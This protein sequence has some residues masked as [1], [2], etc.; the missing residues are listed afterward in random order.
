[1]T[2]RFVAYYRVS[3]RKQGIHGLG[4]DA[5]REAVRSFLNGCSWELIGEFA[6]V[7]SGKRNKREE[8]QKALAL[9]RQRK[10]TLVIAKLD[11]LSRN[12]AF[13]L[14]LQEAGVEFKAVDMPEADRFMVGIMA[15][16]AQKE[17]EMISERTRQ[18]LRA[19][20]RRGTQLGNPNPHDALKAAL[21]AKQ[22]R[23]RAF[24]EGLAPIV[25][26]IQKAG[27]TSLRQLAF[28]LN[29]RGYKTP[30]GKQ[31]RPQSVKDLLRLIR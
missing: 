6:E 18:G 25:K 29:A 12:A 21:K 30:K 19:A 1:M 9:C 10:A 15:L 13:L 17:R 8:L 4:M 2:G 7:E 24:A 27:M 14:N 3:T 5:Q 16:V 26:Q 28:C 20:R 23:S 22:E 11:R 31:F